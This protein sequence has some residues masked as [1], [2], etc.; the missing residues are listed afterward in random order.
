MRTR[1]LMVSRSKRFVRIILPDIAEHQ[2]LTIDTKDPDFPGHD[3]TSHVP[4]DT[5]AVD[6]VGGIVNRPYPTSG[7][8]ADI[9]ERTES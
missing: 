8:T 1:A 5:F 7:W 4:G 9:T 2:T 3:F 6:L